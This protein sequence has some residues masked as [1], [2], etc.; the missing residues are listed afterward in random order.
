MSYC[1]ICGAKEDI[2]KHHIIPKIK[3]GTNE[4]DNIICLC[5]GCHMLIHKLGIEGEDNIKDLVEFGFEYYLINRFALKEYDK[6]SIETVDFE[7]L[8]SFS[9]FIVN[10]FLK[11]KSNH[12]EAIKAG[13]KKAKA[14]GK[15][16]GRPALTIDTIPQKVKDMYSLFQLNQISKTDYAKLCNISRPTLDKYLK[17]IK[18][19]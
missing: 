14:K 15:Q 9:K 11:S 13:M 8:T 18:G 3:G 4:K 17:V 12:S 5:R 6:N 2:D 1:R 16:F 19:E 7:L 10:E